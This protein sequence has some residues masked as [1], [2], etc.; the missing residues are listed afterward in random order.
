MMGAGLAAHL[1]YGTWQDVLFGQ[2]LWLTA[3]WIGCRVIDWSVA[4]KP[5]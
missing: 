3:Y 5:G 4:R 2:A 1:I